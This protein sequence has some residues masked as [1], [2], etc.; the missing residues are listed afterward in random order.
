MSAVYVGGE[1]R[2]SSKVLDLDVRGLIGL[3]SVTGLFGIVFT[4]LAQGVPVQIPPEVAGTVGAAIGFYFGGKGAAGTEQVVAAQVQAAA[5][6]AQQGVTLEEV[7]Q[8]T[9]SARTELVEKISRL[10]E[11]LDASR[12]A[13]ADARVETAEARPFSD[14]PVPV[15]VVGQPVSVQHVEKGKGK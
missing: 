12:L 13:T 14:D 9:N 2:K 6:Q 7:H 4:Q 10:Q 1:R 5:T 8:L 15:E 3:M 11:A